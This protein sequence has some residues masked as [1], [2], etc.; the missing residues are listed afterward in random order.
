[1]KRILSL[2]AVILSAF[3]LVACSLGG[4]KVNKPTPRGKEV[5]YSDEV[6]FEELNNIIENVEKTEG[7]YKLQ[8]SAKVEDDEN[9]IEATVTLHVNADTNEIWLEVSGKGKIEGEEFEAKLEVYTDLENLFFSI[10]IDIEEDNPIKNGKYVLDISEFDFDMIEDLLPFDIEDILG[11]VDF[12]DLEDLEFEMEDFEEVFAMLEMLAD[13]DILTVYRSAKHFTVQVKLDEAIMEANELEDLLEE[14][15]KEIEMIVIFEEGILQ[16]FY[17]SVVME[18]EEMKANLSVR[19]T[20]VSKAPK[21]PKAS[22]Y[23]K[24]DNIFEIFK[25][26]PFE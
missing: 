10:D 17:A 25:E 26:N 19:L 14:G 3:L 23:Q 18:N 1:M 12:D 5:E 13:M 21:V 6:I 4:N 8:V 16:D 20:G 22:D 7:I 9:K 24:I 2:V 15:I 11:E